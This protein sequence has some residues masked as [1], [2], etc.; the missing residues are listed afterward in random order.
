MVDIVILPFSTSK[1]PLNWTAGFVIDSC[2]GFK[3][4]FLRFVEFWYSGNTQCYVL[5]GIVRYM[6]EDSFYLLVR[7][8]RDRR[9]SFVVNLFKAHSRRE[10]KNSKLH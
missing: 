5:Y 3:F 8:H 2:C 10:R 7:T 9:F 6:T 1:S 4:H